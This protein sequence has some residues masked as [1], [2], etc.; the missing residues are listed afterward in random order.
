MWL[1]AVYFG[2]RVRK[3]D[4]ATVRAFWWS[5][6]ELRRLR[7]TLGPRGLEATV[8]PPPPLEPYALRGVRF[9]TSVGRASCLE[10]SLILQQWFGAHGTTYDILVGVDSSNSDFKAHA[11]LEGYDDPVEEYTI[12]T[13]R[14]PDGSV[15]A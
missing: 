8:V 13:R 14:P 5:I 6:G 2:S 3:I 9:A 1:V 11:W 7:R 12:L 4:R 15:A 10:R